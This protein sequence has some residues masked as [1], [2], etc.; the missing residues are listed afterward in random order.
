MSLPVQNVD[1]LLAWHH[2][3]SLP[4]G[5]QEKS[6][7]SP[8]IYVPL[9]KCALFLS[10]YVTQG[11]SELVC[12][13]WVALAE[14][15]L[16]MCLHVVTICSVNSLHPI[17]PQGH[18]SQIPYELIVENSFCFKYEYNDPVSS[19]IC[20]SWQLSCWNMCKIVSWSDY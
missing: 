12:L 16:Q 9:G 5:Q 19:L 3:P 11:H 20:T 1:Y 10:I 6:S 14:P 17:W 7:N 4:M 15:W 18:M 8:N 13:P 2:F